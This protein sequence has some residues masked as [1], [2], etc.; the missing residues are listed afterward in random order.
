MQSAERRTQNGEKVRS[1]ELGVR[2]CGEQSSDY[3]RFGLPKR[4]ISARRI[5]EANYPRIAD[6]SI[7]I[8]GQRLSA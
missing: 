8:S 6:R 1:E 3:I 7:K 4:L 2:S 5:K